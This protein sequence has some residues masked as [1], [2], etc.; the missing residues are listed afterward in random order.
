MVCVL[1]QRAIERGPC[2]IKAWV[3]FSTFYSLNTVMHFFSIKGSC[4]ILYNSLIIYINFI[5]IHISLFSLFVVFL[6][7][8]RLTIL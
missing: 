5:R 3:V 6:F 1:E 8:D 4:L 7:L 2:N